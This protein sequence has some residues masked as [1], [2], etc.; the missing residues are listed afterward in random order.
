MSRIRSIPRVLLGALVAFSIGAAGEARAQSCI[1]SPNDPA[2]YHLK[3]SDTLF[4]IMTQAINTAR[5]DADPAV[6]AA[7]SHLFYDGTGSGNAESQMRFTTP[8]PH[9]G[10]QSIGPMSRNFRPNMIDTLAVGYT[11]RSAGNLSAVGHAAWAPT[12]SNVVGLDAAVFVFRSTSSCPLLRFRTLVDSGTGVSVVRGNVNDKTL[13]TNFGNGGAFNNLNPTSNYSNTMMILLSGPDGSGTIAACSDPRRVQAA[14]DLAGCLGGGIDHLEHIFR[15]DDNSGTTDT[16]K[17]R[18]IVTASS[19]DTRYP[20]VGGR[21]CNGKA[22]GGIDGSVDKPGFCSISRTACSNTAPCTAAQGIC[23]FNLNNQDYDPIRRTCVASDSTH[24]PTTCTNVLTGTSCV[25]GDANCTQGLVVALS[26]TDPG[27]TDITTSIAARVKNDITGATIGYAG[28]EAITGN[29][30]TKAP[31]LENQTLKAAPSPN[32]VRGEQY[33]LARRLFLQNGGLSGGPNDDLIDDLAGPNIGTQVGQ[34]A[35]QFTAEQTF[36]TWTT[37][38]SKIDPIVAQFGF[39]TCG[40][41]GDDHCSLPTSNLCNKAPFVA[42]PS[43]LGAIFPTD[44]AGGQA[45][46]LRSDGTGATCS[47]TAACVS[48]GGSCASGVCPAANA[49]P[50]NSACSQNS[51]CASGH[52]TDVLFLGTPGQGL[53]CSP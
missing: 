35:S 12:C 34:G 44:V 51:D 24:A 23:Q 53:L 3:G 32:N 19:A 48:T 46:A 1:V 8:S 5:T 33:M 27:S 50:L 9:M 7:A 10:V 45:V 52:C 30:G 39:I 6:R 41:I 11:Q 20:F 17:D 43:P 40:N 28:R 22:I 38:A 26:D 21:F 29:K 42:V 15:R 47:G 4:D 14:Q 16:I 36:F 18:I 31:S 2:C 25:A 37:D 13:A 49:R